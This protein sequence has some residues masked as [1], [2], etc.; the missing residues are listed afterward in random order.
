MGIR[1]G[2]LSSKALAF[3]RISYSLKELYGSME[4]SN[5]IFSRFFRKTANAF[6]GFP[7]LFRGVSHKN[8]DSRKN[9]NPQA[10]C[11]QHLG[12]DLQVQV[13]PFP[14]FFSSLAL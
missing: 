3:K 1:F 12:L 13:V 14:A 10:S 7:H 5:N 11:Y 9:V 2:S 8:G 6:S 4:R